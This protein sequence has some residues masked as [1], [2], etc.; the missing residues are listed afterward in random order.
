[1]TSDDLASDPTHDGTI[2]GE[3]S[4]I[5]T[6]YCP[7]GADTTSLLYEELYRSLAH[8]QEEGAVPNTWQSLDDEVFGRRFDPSPAHDTTVIQLAFNAD[9]G[10]ARAWD[11][12]GRQ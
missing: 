2:A 10:T 12:M 5:V 4:L 8:I 11:K 1:M 9:D 3:A 7:R 6:F